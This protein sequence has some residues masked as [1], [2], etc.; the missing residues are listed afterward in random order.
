VNPEPDHVRAAAVQ[1][2]AGVV[3]FER[4]ATLAEDFA[5]PRYKPDVAERLEMQR[6]VEHA[7]A[8][9]AQHAKLLEWAR[10]TGA[11]PAARVA[12]AAA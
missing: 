1:L 12:R 9:R 4:V 10:R 11:L 8:W 6:A 3:L 7:N 5:S 2:A